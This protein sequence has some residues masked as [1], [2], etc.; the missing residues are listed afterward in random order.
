MES[1][2]RIKR[3][4]RWK[5]LTTM[6]GLI[7]GLLTIVT[8]AHITA[9]KRILEKES[10]R[11][12]ALKKEILIQRAKTLS[13]NLAGRA[14]NDIAAFNFSNITEV[15]IKAVSEDN[16]LVFAILMDSSR[17]AYIHT[18][19][20]KLQQETLE[21]NESIFAVKQQ[22]LT[23]NEYSVGGSE[24][25][26]YIAPLRISTKPWGVLRLAFSLDT[27]NHEIV[28]S[29]REIVAQTKS[30]VIRSVITAIVF[31]VLG[32]T[33]VLIVS[34]K[35][36]KPLTR[37]TESAYELA[38]GNFAAAEAIQVTSED[39]VGVLSDAFVVM[40]E[41]LRNSYEKLEDYSKTLEEKVAERTKKLS[42]AVENLQTAQSQL[43]ESEKMASLGGLVA[44]IA[45][46]I[47]T[48]VGIGVTAASLLHDQTQAF[49]SAFKDGTMKKSDLVKYIDTCMQGSTMI[50]SNLHR[51]AELMQ[52]F[53][54][55]AVDQSSENRRVFNV[56]AYL[57]EI[58]LS[59]RPKLKKTKHVVTIVCDSAIELDSY[60]GAFSQIMTNLILNSLIHAFE[61]NDQ[62]H[63]TIEV[64]KNNGSLLL[65]YSDDGKG[66]EPAA[67]DH[68]FD[69][70]Y[71]TKRG[72]GG[73]GLGLHLV[74]NLVTQKLKGSIKCES[75]VDKGA[76]FY[77]SLPLELEKS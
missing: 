35:L 2:S 25:V 18:Q 65:V 23:T 66:I 19:D 51:A 73:S 1:K 54:Q 17:T 40:S 31:I 68:I 32:A 28:D 4:I 67:L 43:V 11:R 16:D 55:V 7:I 6:I 10:E 47:N 9:H 27:V 57:E 56:E 41:N 30:M 59:L 60:P 75:E 74:Y 69:P 76:I 22:E 58:L 44:G 14:E 5:L 29:R 46:E 12:I 53:K 13:D 49:D 33:I 45:H 3:G 50:L 39:E 37:L 20:P 77:I 72:Q 48:P 36:S 34:T 70:F 42:Q 15:I 62:G 52:S 26:E 71:T 8:Y 64:K 21:D 24:F 61:E 38:K 63:P